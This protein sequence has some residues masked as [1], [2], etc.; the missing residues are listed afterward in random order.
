MS[1]FYNTI[2]KIISYNVIHDWYSPFR[3]PYE[4]SSIGTG[5]FINDQGYILTCCHVVEDSIKLEIT[6][7]S[8]GKNIYNAEI[9][10]ISPDYDLALLKTDYENK[11]NFL[12]L[13]DSDMIKQ[14]DN[15]SAVGYPLGQENLKLTSGIIS[16]AQD[17][18]IQTDAPINPGNS[19]GPLVDKNNK[20]IAVNSQ[21]ISADT[22]DNIGFA[23][24][25]NFYKLLESEFKIMKNIIYKPIFL[26]SFSKIDKF[27]LDYYNL[28]KLKGGYLINKI[29]ENCCL[30]KAGLRQYDILL[31]INDF[32]IDNYGEIKVS[33]NI[34]KINLKNLLYRF[35]LGEKIKIKYFSK[36]FK[37]KDKIGNE[38][39]INLNLEYP[40]FQ[41]KNE[42]LNYNRSEI[43]FEIISGM[44]ICNFTINHLHKNQIYPSG[45]SNKNIKELLSFSK[46][47]NR[48]KKK[49][50]LVNVLPGS[51]TY[52]N[53]DIDA[54]VFLEK[55]NDKEINNLNDFRN[56]LSDLKKNNEN[57]I[58]FSFSNSKVI[59]LNFENLKEQH[60]KLSVDY[61]Y[62]TTKLF[63][64]LFNLY[65][66]KYSNLDPKFI[67]KDLQ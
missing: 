45:I 52:S 65:I 4:N 66:V 48:F 34:E 16:G 7:P 13:A 63:E 44:V 2:C 15:V 18:L 39:T 50:I 10:S 6:I 22:A 9:I 33:W 24:P 37:S 43:D 61:N 46:Y 49:I 57:F 35:K 25:I 28:K 31:E 47:E 38:I 42:Y 20:V 8:L 58:K 23:V 41:I 3:S 67:L 21:K 40:K 59:I 12:E 54:G 64:K 11:K 36:N 17:Y 19:G 32:K 14:G 30:Y 26:C 29:D 55:L 53:N 51:Y 5:F 27:I 62:N 56:L 1:L 60:K